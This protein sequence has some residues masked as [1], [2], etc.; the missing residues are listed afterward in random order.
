MNHTATWLALLLLVAAGPAL[1]V[2]WDTGGDLR[3]YQFLTLENLPGQREH[4][5]FGVL[6]LK[7]SS[8]LSD[9]WSFEVHGVLEATAPARAAVSLSAITRRGRRP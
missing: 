6:R 9:S 5:E 4:S 3:Y 7:A 2:D 1:A 8:W